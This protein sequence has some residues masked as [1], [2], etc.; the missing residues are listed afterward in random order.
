MKASFAFAAL[1]ALTLTLTPGCGL[2]RSEY[3]RQRDIRGEY[4]SQLSEIRQANETIGRNISSTYKEI[5]VL[6]IRLELVEAEAQ[7]E[8]PLIPPPE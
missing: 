2:N 7:S 6:R 8:S 3:D 4:L 1:A 5:A